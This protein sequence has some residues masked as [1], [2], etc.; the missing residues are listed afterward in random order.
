MRLLTRRQWK[1]KVLKANAGKA[2][3]FTRERGKDQTLGDIGS[4]S[5]YIGPDWQSDLV[6]VFVPE[7]SFC[8]VFENHRTPEGGFGWKEYKTK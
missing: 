8:S 6:G 3:R 2:V 7:D 4:S 5:A 1:K